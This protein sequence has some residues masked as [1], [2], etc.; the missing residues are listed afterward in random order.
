MSIGGEC[1][2]EGPQGR[3][4]TGQAVPYDGRAR[5]FLQGPADLTRLVTTS[6]N[7]WRFT[8]SYE[9]SAPNRQT[10]LAKTSELLFSPCQSGN[11]NEW[12]PNGMRYTAEQV[13]G[14]GGGGP[15]SWQFRWFFRGGGS[16]SPIRA[17]LESPL[18]WARAGVSIVQVSDRQQALVEVEIVQSIPNYPQA[19]GLYRW[20]GAGRPE[21]LLVRQY[22]ESATFGEHLT[23]HEFGHAVFRV[24]DMIPERGFPYY[25]IGGIMDYQGVEKYPSEHEV[26]DCGQWLLGKGILA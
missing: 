7:Q 12:A 22:V 17:A 26:Q 3:I 16:V 20:S 19:A 2:V 8:L 11:V 4:I 21:V 5:H 9:G 25:H 24:T 18:G 14:G 6:D 15:S 1:V 10:F 13:R 23:N